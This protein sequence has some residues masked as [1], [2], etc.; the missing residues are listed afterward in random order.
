MTSKVYIVHSIHQKW[1]ED[2]TV[3]IS[4]SFRLNTTTGKHT[5]P[6]VWVTSGGQRRWGV[7]NMWFRRRSPAKWA[8]ALLLGFVSCFW[9]LFEA[10]VRNC[11]HISVMVMR[12]P[13][14]SRTHCLWKVS[15]NRKVYPTV[16]HRDNPDLIQAHKMQKIE[17]I[18]LSNPSYWDMHAHSRTHARTRTYQTNKQMK[19][20]KK[21][22]RAISTQD[23]VDL[24]TWR[25]IS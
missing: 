11:S 13:R 12:F 14:G 1:W 17:W 3:L 7:E 8:S 20:T 2:V 5:H 18:P 19:E 15:L 25:N 6:S 4:V 9:E 23:V 16:P 10:C 21:E 24:N 22:R